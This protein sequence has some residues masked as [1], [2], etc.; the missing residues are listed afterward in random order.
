MLPPN[1]AANEII[2]DKPT[3]KLLHPPVD[4]LDKY[5]STIF[6]VSGSKNAVQ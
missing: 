4:P 6:P 1:L 3:M 2:L 5:V